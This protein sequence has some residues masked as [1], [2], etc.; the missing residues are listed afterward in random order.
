MKPT[1]L[2]GRLTDKQAVMTYKNYEGRCALWLWLKRHST[3]QEQGN[4]VEATTL[5]V[6]HGGAG[7]ITWSQVTVL[8]GLIKVWGPSAQ[9]FHLHKD[10]SDSNDCVWKNVTLNELFAV[11][12]DIYQCALEYLC[13][14]I[15][16]F[17]Q[18]SGESV[19]VH[20]L[21]VAIPLHLKSQLRKGP[22]LGG[23]EGETESAD[24]MPFVMLT[25]K[26]N[27]QQVRKALCYHNW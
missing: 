4:F 6:W 18:R 23:G 13:F 20:Q 10:Y 5:C 27:K 14:F 7:V 8:H 3:L 22:P 2:E 26:G 1:S 17:K 9:R 24:T 16:V 25:R 21:D 12:I 19:K 15:S 11:Y